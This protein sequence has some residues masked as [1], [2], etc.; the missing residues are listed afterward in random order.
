[1]RAVMRPGL[2]LAAM[3]L[4]ALAAT[5]CHREGCVGGDDGKCVPPSACGAIVYACAPGAADRLSITH[6]VKAGARARGP[7]ALAAKD[8]FLL[9]NDRIRA[10]LDSVDP[11]HPQGL[12][13]TGGTIID[14]SPVDPD[15]TTMSTTPSSGDQ[16]NGIFQAAGVLPRDAVHYETWEQLDHRVAQD[17]AD[18]YVGVIFRGHLEGD[19]RVTVV[20]RYELRPCEPGLRV[21]TDLYNGARDPNTFSLTDGYFWGDRTL[22]PFLP[23]QGHGFRVPELELLHLDRAWREWPFMAA[24]AQAEPFVSYAVVPCDHAVGEIGRA[25]CRE[26]VYR[27]V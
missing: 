12:A 18:A 5:G 2:L 6:I 17:G 23:I 21:R 8:D 13:P 15:A 7:K 4:G 16:L 22:L 25:S 26:R 1:M 9:E 10:V 19:A 27:H 24:R 20:T 14:L 11:Q 3:S